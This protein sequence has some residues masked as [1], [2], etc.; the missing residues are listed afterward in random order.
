MSSLQHLLPTYTHRGPSARISGRNRPGVPGRGLATH[1]LLGGV[2]VGIFTIQSSTYFVGV[3]G[4][5]V[6]FRSISE[7]TLRP[8]RAFPPEVRAPPIS[9]PEA[10]TY[11]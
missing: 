2:E 7:R 11:S 10:W 1:F 4:D 8:G 6:V 3:D 9:P 5:L